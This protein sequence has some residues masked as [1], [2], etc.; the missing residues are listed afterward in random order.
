M[1]VGSPIFWTGHRISELCPNFSLRFILAV[2]YH[3]CYGARNLKSR[4]KTKIPT[5]TGLSSPALIQFQIPDPWRILLPCASII[6]LHRCTGASLSLRHFCLGPHGCKYSLTVMT[7]YPFPPSQR[8]QPPLG[9]ASHHIT[10]T[11]TR[12]FRRCPPRCSIRRTG[13]R[14]RL[15]HR[16]VWKRT[17]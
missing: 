14:R 5:N 15:V 8:G 16:C 12:E 6:T 13:C 3:G 17:A 11:E 7:T 4:Q 9:V 10:S 2:Q 1:L